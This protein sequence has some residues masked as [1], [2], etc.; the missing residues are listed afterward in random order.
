M[1]FEN[2]QKVDEYQGRERDALETFIKN[3]N[4]GGLALASGKTFSRVNLIIFISVF[5]L[6][7]VASTRPVSRVASASA[8]QNDPSSMVIFFESSL[9]PVHLLNGILNPST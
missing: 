4:R 6:Y 5:L 3:N 7:R 8:A 1:V 2:G 9:K